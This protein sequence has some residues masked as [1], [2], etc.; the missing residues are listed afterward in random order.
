M[1][2]P[3]AIA[4]CDG[5]VEGEVC[6]FGAPPQ[7]GRCT[8][9]PMGAGLTCTALPGGGNPGGGFP[10][11][12]IHLEVAAIHQEVG[13]NLPEAAINRAATS[14]ATMSSSCRG[15]RYTFRRR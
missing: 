1:P 15:R 14:V 8:L 4:A 3:A 9:L 10:G 7:S 5:R 6:T 13:A 2:D 11:G 12:G